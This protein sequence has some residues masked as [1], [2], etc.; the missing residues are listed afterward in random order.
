MAIS[1]PWRWSASALSSGPGRRAQGAHWPRSV[2]VSLP[3]PTPPR[4]TALIDSWRTTADGAGSEAALGAVLHA[5]SLRSSVHPCDLQP[6]CLLFRGGKKY[7]NTHIPVAGYTVT[8]RALVTLRVTRSTTTELTTFCRQKLRVPHAVIVT[9]T[10][11]KE[12]RPA[13]SRTA[14]LSRLAFVR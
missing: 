14:L 1:P 10:G 9:V 7:E 6:G 11:R 8:A 2:G 13:V 4:S 12:A 5:R 3:P